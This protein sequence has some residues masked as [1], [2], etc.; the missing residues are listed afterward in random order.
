MPEVRWSRRAQAALETIDLVVRDQLTANA[1]EVLHYIPRSV[2]YP[3]DE[4]LEGDVMWHR[5]ITCGIVSEELLAREDEDGP[6]N[7]FFFY[8][9]GVFSPGG[10]APRPY[11]EILA[12]RRIN[13]ADVA[14]QWEKMRGELP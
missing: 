4:G 11:F 13:V 5:G 14:E 10:P 7:Y 3:H 8:R 6:W 1:G 2:L 9:A 12:L